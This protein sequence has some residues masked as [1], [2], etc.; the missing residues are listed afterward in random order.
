MN[1]NTKND[2]HT[3][4]IGSCFAMVEWDNDRVQWHWCAAMFDGTILDPE[5]AHGHTRNMHL[6]RLDAMNWIRARVPHAID[7]DMDEDCRCAR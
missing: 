5:T 1:W 4:E 7:C 2:K 6:A 3:A